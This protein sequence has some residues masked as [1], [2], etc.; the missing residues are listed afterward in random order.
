MSDFFPI[1]PVIFPLVAAVLLYILPKD[2]QKIHRTLTMLVTVINSVLVLLVVCFPPEG[3]LALLDFEKQL[4]VNLALSIKV[5]GPGRF[6]GGLIALLWPFAL[7]YAFGYMEK[8]KRQPIFYLFYTLSFGITA[9]IAFSGNLLTLYVFY[10]MLTMATMPLIMHGYTKEHRRA[11]VKYAA[12]SL[13]G[14][15]MG[16]MGLMYL[17]YKTGSTDFVYGGMLNGESSAL[18]QIMF[19]I[20][21]FGFG[22]KAAIW[23]LSYWLPS[24]SVAPTPVTALLHAVAVV[25]AGAFALIRLVYYCFG[26][27]TL[28]GTVAAR[29]ALCFA[30]FTVVYGSAKALR[31]GHFKRR[32]AWSTV[33]NLSY[34]IAGV[35]LCSKA[36]LQAAIFHMAAHAITKMGAFLCAGSFMHCTGKERVEEL[37]GIG[38]KMPLTFLS[39][40]FCS[41]SLIGVPLFIGFSSKWM[42]LTAAWGDRSAFGVLSVTTLLLSAFLTA[43]YML[44]ICI[45]AFFPKKGKDLYAGSTVKEAGIPMLLPTLLFALLTLLSGIFS[46]WLFAL[47]CSL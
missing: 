4:G 3:E 23:P 19:L 39:F 36:G 14:A 25:K 22:V 11:A 5:D 32:L 38:K 33:S 31:S 45:K 29:I 7:M 37:E 18:V 8:S 17:V 44:N 42:L 34:I 43:I 35:M 21:F 24:A 9:G 12:Y 1:L 6:F 27:E 10:E 46:K 20:C 28:H 26:A 41:L 40:L 2:H 47:I 15:A 30:L 13:G 16:F